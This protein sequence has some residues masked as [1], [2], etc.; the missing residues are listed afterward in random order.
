MRLIEKAMALLPFYPK[1]TKTILCQG[2]YSFF[3]NLFA[4]YVVIVA[5]L[6]Y[7][8]DGS[9]FQTI[10]FGLSASDGTVT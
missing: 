10:G 4:R 7:E 2:L 9:S 5:E 8:R 1:P 3:Y 6:A